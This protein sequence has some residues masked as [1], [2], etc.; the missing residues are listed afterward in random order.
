M[1]KNKLLIIALLISI[2]SEAQVVVS[3]RVSSNRQLKKADS[4]FAL[5]TYSQAISLYKNLPENATVLYK[6]AM[7]YESSGN[8]KEALKYY[9]AAL[10]ISKNSLSTA[11]RYGKLLIKSAQYKKADSLFLELVNK[12]PKNANY[13][14]HLA[15]AKEKQKDTVALS[16][17][18]RA[19]LLDT[20]MIHSAYKT[21]V[22]LIQK[23]Q[24]NQ[25]EKYINTGLYN[26]SLSTRFLALKATLLYYNKKYHKAKEIY[27]KLI[28][29]GKNN[30]I[31]YANLAKTYMKVSDYEN[32][33]EQYLILVKN[34]DSE[35]PNYHHNLGICYRALHYYDKAE[36]AFNTS[37]ALNTPF[38]E[39]DYMRLA[40]LYNA[41]KQYKKQLEIYKKLLMLNP[42]NE[43]ATYRQSV[44]ADNFFKDKK[45]VL[46]YYNGYLKK[47]SENGKYSRLVKQ[48]IR[49]IKK[50]LHFLDT[51]KN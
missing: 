44:A 37:V 26:D 15:L 8:N 46:Q 4:L 45:T 2:L 49:D 3:D 38:L 1:L 31:V 27:K 16:L 29:L 9:K 40:D 25:A 33:I 30:E 18:K 28:A 12:Q 39:N 21:A 20:T 5:G 17:Y 42:E 41:Q 48:R 43:E 22:L 47:H 10:K 51:E 14:Y 23:K 19:Y 24:F 11:Y 50:E 7:C 32:A 35:N 34:H 13:V 6:L 36:E